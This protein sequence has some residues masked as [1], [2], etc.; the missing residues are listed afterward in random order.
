MKAKLDIFE[1][2]IDREG[3]SKYTNRAADRG[4]GTRW[5]LTEVNA[6]KLGYT[7]DMAQLPKE[8]AI[9]FLENLWSCMKID[10]LRAINEH[11]G[12][13][14]F[15]FGYNSGSGNAVRELQELINLLNN[16]ETLFPDV[17]EDGGMGAQTLNA[18]KS[19]SKKGDLEALAYGYN[20]IRVAFCMDIARRDHSQE[21]NAR[22]WLNR[23]YAVGRA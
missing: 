16:C 19:F 13:Y 17:A 23:I 18:I 20:A 10:E 11:L 8:Y 21:Q 4:K 7:G 2:I 14:A 22:G 5:G 9:R 1:E 15:D 3:G 6:R 12:E